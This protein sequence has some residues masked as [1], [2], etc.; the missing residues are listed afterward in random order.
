MSRKKKLWRERV[1]SR[2][3]TVTVFERKPDGPLTMRWWEPDR[4]DMKWEALGHSDKDK[5]LAEAHETAAKLRRGEAATAAG[6]TILATLF[7]QYERHR[8]PRKSVNEQKADARRIELWTRYLGAEKTVHQITLGEWETFIDERR[9]GAICPHGAHGPHNRPDKTE[10]PGPRD[11]TVRDRVIEADLKW[12]QLV[13]GWGTKWRDRRGSPSSFPEGRDRRACASL[14]VWHRA[15]RGSGLSTEK[16]KRQRLAC[17]DVELE[18]DVFRV[19]TDRV[20]A[21][22]ETLGDLPVR[23]SPREQ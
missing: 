8:T 3:Y 15:P 9:T 11:R 22:G 23:K 10:C 1:G 17:V 7:V 20:P 12:L 13:A 2:P 21:D 4:G 16:T 6:E 5:A 19:M 14:R 18:E